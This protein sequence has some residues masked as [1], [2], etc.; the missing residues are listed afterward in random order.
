[1]A[2][3]FRATRENFISDGCPLV[4]R[5]KHLDDRSETFRVA[6]HRERRGRGVAR[7]AVVN[8]DHALVLMNGVR[9]TL[10]VY[11]GIGDPTGARLAAAIADSPTYSRAC[12]SW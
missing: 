6:A 9:A 4:P 10:R 11:E 1:M 12:H 3:H 2:E 8:D 5:F 7:D